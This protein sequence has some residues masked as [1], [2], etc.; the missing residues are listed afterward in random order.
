MTTTAA[1]LQAITS[2]KFPQTRKQLETYLAMTGDLR[3][4]IQHYAQKSEAL[5]QRKT[6][7]LHGSPIKGGPRRA[8]SN[9]T[10]LCQPT[11]TELRAFD[12]LQAKFQ[13]PC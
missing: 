3:H 6:A 2:L 5:Q 13:N 10:L 9:Q 11:E 8:W 1:K 7:L 12:T 4:Y